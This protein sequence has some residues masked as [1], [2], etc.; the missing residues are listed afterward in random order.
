MNL[1]CLLAVELDNEQLSAAADALEPA[2]RERRQRR[3]ERLQRVDPGRQRGLD[4]SAG[5][6]ATDQAC[7][8]LDFG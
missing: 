1:D 7:G 6:G 5:D 3:V 2:S 4:L 8:D